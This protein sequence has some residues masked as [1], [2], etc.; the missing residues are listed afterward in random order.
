M[1]LHVRESNRQESWILDFAPWIPDFFVSGT[2][3]LIR[4]SNR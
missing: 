4:D 3:I 1:S 2:C